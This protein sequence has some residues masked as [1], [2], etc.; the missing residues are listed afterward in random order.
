MFQD[1]KQ[2]QFDLK[3][4]F[5]NLVFKDIHKG[6]MISKSLNW[7]LTWLDGATSTWSHMV[8]NSLIEILIACKF[9]KDE[10]P[11]WMK[12]FSFGLWLEICAAFL[13]EFFL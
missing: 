10:A 3:P 11:V 5:C 12:N 9:D 8:Y 6:N 13:S 2:N 4:I 7:R 1:D